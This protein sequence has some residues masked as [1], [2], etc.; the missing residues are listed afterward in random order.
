MNENTLMP[1][2]AGTVYWRDPAIDAPPQGSKLLLLTSG[3]V[4]VVGQWMS[5]S[6]MVAWSPLPKRNLQ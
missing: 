3:G 1:A 6:N 5:D 4:A 2:A